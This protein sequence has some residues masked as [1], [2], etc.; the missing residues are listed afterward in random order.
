MTGS[1]DLT[2]LLC[3]SLA[4]VRALAISVCWL[5]DYKSSK[6]FVWTRRR[7]KN[8]SFIPY[9]KGSTNSSFVIFKAT[10]RKAVDFL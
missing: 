5:K 10:N 6:C 2:G 4:V 3:C 9:L 8:N 7:S 1:V